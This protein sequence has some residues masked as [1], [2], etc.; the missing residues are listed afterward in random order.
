MKKIITFSFSTEYE[1]SGEEEVFT[2]EELGIDENMKDKE[3]EKVLDKLF[4]DWVW[5]KFNISGGIII[6][7]DKDTIK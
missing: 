7:K 4:H 2:F 6:T 3:I 5:D 1:G